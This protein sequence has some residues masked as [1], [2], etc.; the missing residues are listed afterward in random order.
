MMDGDDGK[1]KLLAY[2]WMDRNRRYFIASASSLEDGAENVRKRWRQ[3]NEESD[4]DPERVE[5]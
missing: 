5:L 1:P 3:I 4:A 2:V